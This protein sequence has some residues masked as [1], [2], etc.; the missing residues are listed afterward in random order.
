MT[1]CPEC[2]DVG[3]TSTCTADGLT[4]TDVASVLAS[5]SGVGDGTI[6]N[7]ESTLGNLTNVQHTSVETLCEIDNVGPTVAKRIKD[8]L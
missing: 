2:G 1:E 5:T 4:E 3:Y 8:A 6:Q 7:I